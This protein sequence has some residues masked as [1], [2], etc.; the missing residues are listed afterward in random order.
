MDISASSDVSL[1]AGQN[2]L[3]FFNQAHIL[4]DYQ[5]RL[6]LIKISASFML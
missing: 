2:G 6:K 3:L 1:Y 4:T 5:T